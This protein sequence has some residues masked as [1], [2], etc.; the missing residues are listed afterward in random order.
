M[1][2]IC[3]DCSQ[4]I[5]SSIYLTF[6]AFVSIHIGCIYLPIPGT[7]LYDGYGAI[8]EKV[9]ESLEP[10]ITM[11]ADILLLLGAP[12]YNYN[13]NDLTVSEARFMTYYWRADKG[14]WAVA[15]APG[16]GAG[17]YVSIC[18]FLC[19]EFDDAN[20]VKRYKHFESGIIS[21]IFEEDEGYFE[22]EDEVIKWIYD[23]EN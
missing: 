16:A 21:G 4:Q 17:D 5:R 3:K 18:H 10:G 20:R 9:M 1:Q 14:I 13:F 15:I 23:S 22:T 7:G 11:R 19:I 12:N 6:L 8:P 2:R